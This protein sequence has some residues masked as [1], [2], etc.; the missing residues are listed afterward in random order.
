MLHKRSEKCDKDKTQ[1]FRFKSL[2]WA[3]ISTLVLVIMIVIVLDIYEISK[4]GTAWNS[5][6]MSI[7]YLIIVGFVSYLI[8]CGVIS[9]IIVVRARNRGKLIALPM[10]LLCR[11]RQGKAELFYQFI[12]SLTILLA[13]VAVTIHGIGIVI[14]AFTNPLQVFSTVS[15]VVVA[16]FYFTYMFADIYDHYED[17]FNA[18]NTRGGVPFLVLRLLTHTFVLLFF[19]LFSYIYLTAVIFID[20]DDIGIVNLIANAFPIL[21]VTFCAWLS[22]H[23]LQKFFNFEPSCS[24]I[25]KTEE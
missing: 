9:I 3:V 25:D 5:T 1:R 12:G 22:K 21:L 14:A 13:S 6:S 2:F 17:I 18:S 8:V 24:S 20:G 4:F 23:E 7:Y 10:I 11:K 16:V 15:T 19:F